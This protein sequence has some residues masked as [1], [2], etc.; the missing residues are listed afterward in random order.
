MEPLV[1]TEWL[2]QAIGAPDL[3]VFDAS[4]YLP[5]EQRD[6]RALFEAGHLPGARFFDIDL[7]ADT[8]S[9][10]PHMVPGAARFERLVR[11]LGLRAQSR[12]VCYDQKGIFSSARAWWLLQ[13]F[14]HGAAAVLDGGLP[15]WRREGG[16]LEHGPAS[17]VA[18]GDFRASLHARSLRG[19]GDLLCNLESRAELV[20]DARAPDR[21]DARVP[22]PRAGLRGGHIPG[23]R[24]LPYTDLLVGGETMLP[25]AMLGA[26]FAAEGVGPGSAVVTTCGSGL[27]AA[28]LSLGLAV[29][30]LPRGALYD[31]SW[32][33]WGARPDTPV[34]AAATAGAEIA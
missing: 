19:L 15:R 1:S 6:A 8:D 23:S 27:T 2:A 29:A 24:N 7:I 18:A 9:A 33:E 20:L 4:W 3:V 30:G 12:V 13:L 17:A 5:G 34:S 14:G 26:R 10:L 32:S 31:G 21:F 16:A 22:E 25:P 28:V 11:E